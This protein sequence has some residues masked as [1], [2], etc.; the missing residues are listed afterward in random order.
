M[1]FNIYK[2]LKYCCF[3]PPLFIRPYNCALPL[4]YFQKSTKKYNG[5]KV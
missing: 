4:L 2:K 1:I 5:K 3:R